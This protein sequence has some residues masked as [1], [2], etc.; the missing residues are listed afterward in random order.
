VGVLFVKIALIV[1]TKALVIASYVAL[2]AWLAQ[3]RTKRQQPR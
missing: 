1:A 3:R 2:T